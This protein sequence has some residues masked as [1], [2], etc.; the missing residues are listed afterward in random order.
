MTKRSKTV[1]KD[2]QKSIKSEKNVRRL[3]L[4]FATKQKVGDAED[5]SF[6]LPGNL[7]F[8]G[9][10]IGTRLRERGR[11]GERERRREGE[12]SAKRGREGERGRERGV[13][14]EGGREKHIE[15][16]REKERFEIEEKREKHSEGRDGERNKRMKT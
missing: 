7:R 5:V 14:K 15:R 12:R 16:K 8:C 13:Q 9:S 1:N 6:S 3:F 10:A 4:F 11:E 2:R